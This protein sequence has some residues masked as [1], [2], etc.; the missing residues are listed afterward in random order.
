MGHSAKILFFHHHSCSTTKPVPPPPIQ[1]CLKSVHFEHTQ[2]T[3]HRGREA[4]SVT[5]SSFSDKKLSVLWLLARIL[6][7]AGDIRGNGILR[8]LFKIYANTRTMYV[9]FIA[10]LECLKNYRH[11]LLS[12]CFRVLKQ[13]QLSR[14][15][16]GIFGNLSSLK[17]L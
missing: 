3:L 6:G 5:V 2:S 1:C 7:S 13:N 16:E 17:T 15:P 14:L 12:A 9:L 4:G 10:H 8:T 11:L